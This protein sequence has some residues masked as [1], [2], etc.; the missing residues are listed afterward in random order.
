MLTH[1]INKNTLLVTH[2]RSQ[3]AL[4]GTLIL[5]NVEGKKGL[6]DDLD[7]EL[8]AKIIVNVTKK[9]KGLGSKNDE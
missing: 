7:P 8:I 6:L 5:E 1:S 2:Q 3:E 9:L 4:R